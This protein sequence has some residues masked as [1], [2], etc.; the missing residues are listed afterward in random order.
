ML[1]GKNASTLSHITVS[2]LTER[3]RCSST[4]RPFTS[5]SAYITPFPI[6]EAE[7]ESEPKDQWLTLRVVAPLGVEM[8][9][10]RCIQPQRPFERKL[11]S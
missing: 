7:G 1:G 4:A 3:A 10:L 8:E 6:G 2:A 11:R 5:D 9:L